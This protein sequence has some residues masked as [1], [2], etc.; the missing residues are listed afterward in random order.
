[1]IFDHHVQGARDRDMFASHAV[2]VSC[3]THTL[4]EDF[5]IIN[6]GSSIINIVNN[7]IIIVIQEL[8]T[9]KDIQY[10]ELLSKQQDYVTNL[11]Q[12]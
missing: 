8:G 11:S 2:S 10:L 1:M 5:A 3:L 7:I 9:K 6:R 4:S 12:L